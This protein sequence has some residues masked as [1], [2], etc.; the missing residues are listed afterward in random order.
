[1]DTNVSSRTLEL[2]DKFSARLDSMSFT[3]TGLPGKDE[4]LLINEVWNS[5]SIQ[6]K[7]G[8]CDNVRKDMSQGR[9]EIEGN[10]PDVTPYAMRITLKYLL[11][12]REKNSS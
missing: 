2:I 6:E 11:D 1:M 5:L 8:I 10:L 12:M 7:K 9:S 3:S 4:V